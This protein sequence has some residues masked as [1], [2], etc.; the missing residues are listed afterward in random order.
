M[1]CLEALELKGGDGSACDVLR[2]LLGDVL[3][4]GMGSKCPFTSSVVHYRAQ[5]SIT[6]DGKVDTFPNEKIDSGIAYVDRTKRERRTDYL[7]GRCKRIHQCSPND[8]KGWE[9]N[10]YLLH[11]SCIIGP[12]NQL[13]LMEKLILSLVSASKRLKRYL[14]A[15]TI[16]VITD[17][18]IK[19][20]LSNPE[21]TG[22]ILK[23]SFELEE[24]DIHYIPRT[25]VKGQILADFIVERLKDDPQDT[26]MKDEEAFLD[27]WI[28]FTD[29]SSFIDGFG[30]GLIIT[31]LEGMEF[32]YSLRFRFDA[33]NNE[34]EYVALIAGL[35]I[36]ERMG[37]ESKKAD[38]LSKIVSTSFAHLSKQVLVEELKE[39]SIDEKEVL[40]VVE[41]EGRTWMTP[42]H[43]YLVEEVL[44]EEKEKSKGCTSQS[45]EVRRD[46]WSFVQKIFPRT[47]VTLCQTA[48][49]KLRPKRNP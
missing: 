17:Q 24:H 14:Q 36:A 11:Q 39:K 3:E 10:A 45:K 21:V 32:T 2:W 6:L 43:E 18:S 20:I 15:N 27:P 26:A 44:L 5:K 34:A 7:P 25:S 1:G 47:M 28:L 23:W 16:I 29:R 38:A 9:A 31:N 42:I 35:R 40:V 48:T 4:K 8:R 41:E 46:K 22:R 19:Q 13:H 49:G 33:T 30:A 12:K 37:E